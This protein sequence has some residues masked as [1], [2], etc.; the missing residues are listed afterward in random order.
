MTN[1]GF[2]L[3]CPCC[4][5]YETQTQQKPI[6]GFV[7]AEKGLIGALSFQGSKISKIKR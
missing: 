1:V 7:S 3:T 4:G 6:L 5:G 2:E